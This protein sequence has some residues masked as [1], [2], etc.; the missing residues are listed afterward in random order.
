MPL[1]WLLLLGF[2]LLINGVVFM[3]AP[4][5]QIE[6]AIAGRHEQRKRPWWHVCGDPSPRVTTDISFSLVEHVTATLGAS[7]VALGLLIIGLSPTAQQQFCLCVV[8]VWSSVQ[9]FFLNP[10]ILGPSATAQRI[11]FHSIVIG[12]T[13]CTSILAFRRRGNESDE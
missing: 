10:T 5:P 11:T 1:I 9:L 3:M 2:F 8:L 12:L 7:Y 13:V 4:V 6:A